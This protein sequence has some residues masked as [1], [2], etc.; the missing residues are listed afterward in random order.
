MP[1]GEEN[2]G[3]N[4]PVED[5]K[6]VDQALRDLLKAISASPE[7]VEDFQLN[8]TIGSSADERPPGPDYTSGTYLRRVLLDPANPAANQILVTFV[9]DD[10]QGQINSD[11]LPHPNPPDKNTWAAL[12][13]DPPNVDI[14]QGTVLLRMDSAAENFT[15]SWIP[16]NANQ[17]PLHFARSISDKD[18]AGEPTSDFGKFQE[19]MAT[20]AAMFAPS[21]L[22]FCLPRLLE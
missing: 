13:N 22:T 21:R 20:N 1:N 5:G 8:L 10:P 9:P 7:G 18:A 19:C 14:D 11:S 17:V 6:N 16:N 4:M 3:L 2:G 15:L 12:L